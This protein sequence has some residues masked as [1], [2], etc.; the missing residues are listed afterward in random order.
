MKEIMFEHGDL[1]D[2]LPRDQQRGFEEQAVQFRSKVQN[3]M[4]QER[5]GLEASVHVEIARR[6]NVS[7]MESKS[8]VASAAKLTSEDLEKWGELCGA[9]QFNDASMRKKQVGQA[10]CPEPLDEVTMHAYAAAPLLQDRDASI[11]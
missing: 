2:A 9:K 6:E 10:A 4:E 1:W 8:M 7:S 11:K 5:V 3:E